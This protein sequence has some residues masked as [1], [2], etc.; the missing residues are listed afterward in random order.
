[1]NETKYELMEIAFT[2]AVPKGCNNDEARKRIEA[3]AADA[4]FEMAKKIGKG[5]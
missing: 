4:A 1:M 3:A 2:V 5:K